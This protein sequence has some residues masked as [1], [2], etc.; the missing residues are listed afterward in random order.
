MKSISL[1]FGGHEN[2]EENYHFSSVANA[3][4][5]KKSLLHYSK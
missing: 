5:Q 2:E 1:V 4:R 3:P